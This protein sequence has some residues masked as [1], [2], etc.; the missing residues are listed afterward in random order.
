MQLKNPERREGMDVSMR[1]RLPELLK[2][3]GM[4]AYQFSKATNGRV[5]MSTAYRIVRMR[6]RLANFD[7][8]LLEAICDV[9]KVKPGELFGRERVG[10]QPRSRG[11]PRRPR[12]E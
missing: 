2:K 12:P 8:V 1:L 5:S 3:R 10:P 11:A 7:A 9:L 4:S 6:G